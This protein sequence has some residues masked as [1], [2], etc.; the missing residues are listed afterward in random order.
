M[1][2]FYVALKNVKAQSSHLQSNLDLVMNNNSSTLA[3]EKQV[4]AQALV[5]SKQIEAAKSDMLKQVED[6]EAKLI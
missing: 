4:L 2:V 3:L 6:M 5:I 1:S